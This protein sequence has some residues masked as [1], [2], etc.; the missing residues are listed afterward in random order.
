[1]TL[2]GRESVVLRPTN[3]GTSGEGS[4]DLYPNSSVRLTNKTIHLT[5]TKTGTFGLG[6]KERFKH[7]RENILWD[8]MTC[9]PYCH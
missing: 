1:M 2:V 3:Y 6:C 9:I 5:Q 7:A 4:L 8:A